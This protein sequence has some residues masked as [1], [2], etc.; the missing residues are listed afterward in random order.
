MEVNLFILPFRMGSYKKILKAIIIF[1]TILI[2]SDQIVGRLL[3]KY[4]FSMKSGTNAKITYIA[5]KTNA[6]LLVFGSSAASHNYNT[7]LLEKKLGI[8]SYNAGRDG[9]GLLYSYGLLQMVLQ[10]YTPQ[11]VILDFHPASLNKNYTDDE[12]IAP[13]LPYY[14]DHP[15]IR[16]LILNRSKFE[17]FKMFSK[18]YPYNSLNLGYFSES[19]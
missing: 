12:R 1:I 10:R 16:E 9:T 5:E 13:L 18:I 19:K 11:I 15:E 7:E 2:M 17:K 3:R 6:D 4:Y 14:Q 8:K